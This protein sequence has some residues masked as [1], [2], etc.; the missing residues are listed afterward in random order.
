MAIQSAEELGLEAEVSRLPS[1]TPAE[2]RPGPGQQPAL[3]GQLEPARPGPLGQLPQQLLIGS[4]Q[5]NAVL[6]LTARHV[7]HWCL[8]VC[9]E[10]HR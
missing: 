6:V 4:R 5:L 1:S 9:Q 3:A 2:D 8:L 10:L 7:C